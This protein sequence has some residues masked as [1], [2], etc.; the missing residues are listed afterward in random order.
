MKEIP[1]GKKV[2]WE[3]REKREKR[4]KR[5]KEKRKK[6]SCNILFF[7]TRWQNPKKIC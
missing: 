5:E 1:F 4:F 3:E 6:I 2:S 7:E